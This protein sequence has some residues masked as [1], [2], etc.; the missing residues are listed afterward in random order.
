[1]QLQKCWR[2]DFGKRMVVV[3]DSKS[4]HSFAYPHFL[5]YRFEKVSEGCKA[6]KPRDAAPQNHFER[7]FKFF[8]EKLA[9]FFFLPSFKVSHKPLR[10][11]PVSFRR[12]CY[13]F[14]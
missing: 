2:K 14:R 9:K 5:K 1:M 7:K 6:K 12:F 8:R 3:G 11:E 10:F 4:S 13:C